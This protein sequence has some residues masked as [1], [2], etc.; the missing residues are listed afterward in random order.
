MCEP[1]ALPKGFRPLPVEHSVRRL[2]IE[3]AT[4]G[5]SGSFDDVLSPQFCKDAIDL[6]VGDEIEVAGSGWERTVRVTSVGLAGATVEPISERKTSVAAVHLYLCR[7]RRDEP[8]F[9]LYAR[10]GE[11]PDFRWQRL[12]PGTWNIAVLADEVIRLVSRDPRPD[13]TITSRD[14]ESVK[15]TAGSH[16][17]DKP[18]G[19]AMGITSIL[20]SE[21]ADG[22]S[23]RWVALGRNDRETWTGPDR[24][25]HERTLGEQVLK[26]F[27]SDR[28]FGDGRPDF[29]KFEQ[30]RWDCGGDL[31]VRPRWKGR[32]ICPQAF[33]APP[34][35]SEGF[36]RLAA[37]QREKTL[38]RR[39]GNLARQRAEENARVSSEIDGR[40]REAL[41]AIT[42]KFR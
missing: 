8:L 39:K 16:D 38:A 15:S 1:K 36:E 26:W 42:D 10:E 2:R 29:K 20:C 3:F 22:L 19:R 18:H 35:F 33:P 23:D 28:P 37:E 30:P 27:G 13:V 31:W 21:G 24:R 5:I 9:G 40:Q 4:L 32:E 7:E 11:A 6:R 41:Q 17:E 12:S 14:I 34:K 25:F